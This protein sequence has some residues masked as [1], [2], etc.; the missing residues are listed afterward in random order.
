MGRIESRGKNFPNFQ[1]GGIIQTFD[2]KIFFIFQK[3]KTRE[4]SRIRD[5][6]IAPRPARIGVKMAEILSLQ[7]TKITIFGHF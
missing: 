4:H 1:R 5:E 7:G 6:S 2:P 3:I